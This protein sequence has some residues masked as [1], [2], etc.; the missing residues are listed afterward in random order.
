M[1]A[2]LRVL[3]CQAR[4][5]DAERLLALAFDTCAPPPTL[6]S[7]ARLRSILASLLLRSRY[8]CA[9][10]GGRIADAPRPCAE[11]VEAL[12]PHAN[13]CD[14]SRLFAP[15]RGCEGALRYLHVALHFACL[16]GPPA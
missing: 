4:C 6:R 10:L 5:L 8:H 14:P 13:R 1:G 15:V 9:E 2:H 3:L 11:L 16:L 7:V 12:H